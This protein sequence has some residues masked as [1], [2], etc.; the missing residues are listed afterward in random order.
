M[1][2][3]YFEK[4]VIAYMQEWKYPLVSRNEN[5]VVFPDGLCAKICNRYF[6]ESTGKFEYDWKL[7]SML[8]EVISFEYVENHIP[9]AR[10]EANIIPSFKTSLLSYMRQCAMYAED[11]GFEEIDR[12]ASEDKILG[13]DGVVKLD[14]L[15][16][17]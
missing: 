7:Y 17:E 12:Q 16:G 9:I 15:L 2:K 5:N 11:L 1:N 14:D 8:G 10:F 3:A 4:T 6:D 13:L